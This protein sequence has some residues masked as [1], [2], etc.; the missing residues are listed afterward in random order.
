MIRF[1]KIRVLCNDKSEFGETHAVI[2]DEAKALS[3][4]ERQVIAT[5]LGF[6]ETIF[7]NDLTM[8]NVSFFDTTKE[9]P[10]AGTAALA[11]A[12]FVN[13]H[14]NK[15]VENLICGSKSISTWQ[16][17]GL[18]WIATK[19][20]TMPSWNVTQY[21]SPELVDAI[22]PGEAKTLEHTLAWAWEDRAEGVIRAR[23]LASDWDIPEVEAN[24]SGSMMLAASLERPLRI[25]HGEGS[26]I[27]AKTRPGDVVAIGGKI[28]DDGETEG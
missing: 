12:W 22:T 19:F 9:V 24:G 11:A 7:V 17:D 5:R 25:K 20:D 10:F 13:E 18:T 16:E 6:D 8:G 26:V 28:V 3:P 23:T 15:P 1:H 4:E 2:V 14:T 21:D 27:L